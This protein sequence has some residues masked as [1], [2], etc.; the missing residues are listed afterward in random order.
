M[1]SNCIA[2][3]LG[4]FIAVSPVALDAALKC[5]RSANYAIDST[6]DYSCNPTS[7]TLTA[8]GG[9]D[10]TCN[11]QPGCT[12]ETKIVLNGVCA[13]A[14]SAT[15]GISAGTL[16]NG[17]WTWDK[18]S[19]NASCVEAQDSTSTANVLIKNGT[20]VVGAATVTFT[21]KKCA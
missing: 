19:S 12:F 14:T 1:A 4:F 16:V 6:N 17:K 13:S 11:T 3:L 15:V 2:L 10:G 21:C 18:I 20:T 9:A 7:I 5:K 8:V